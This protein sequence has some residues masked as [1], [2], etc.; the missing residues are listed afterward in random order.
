VNSLVVQSLWAGS[1]IGNGGDIV[2]CR[3]SEENN[4]EGYYSLD[5]IQTRRSDAKTDED[6][7]SA[8]S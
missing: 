3:Q 8:N 1:R 7:V 4:L 2:Y 6:I 5:Y